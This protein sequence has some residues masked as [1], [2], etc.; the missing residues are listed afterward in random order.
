MIYKIADLYVE[1]RPQYNRMTKQSVAYQST[2]SIAPDIVI[3]I[4]QTVTDEFAKSNPHLDAEMCEYLLFGAEFYNKLIDFNGIL[5]HGSAVAVDGEVYIFT[6][7]S[8]VGKSTHTGL[9]L[10]HFG[11]RAEIINDDKPA[12]RVVNDK[13]FA[14]GTPFS[15]KYDISK[16]I[17][18]PL[19]AIC[20]IE[21][22]E[23]D[24]IS[25]V[26]KKQAYFEILNQSVRPKNELAYS[27]VLDILETIINNVPIYRLKA[28][29]S[30]N[31]VITSYEGMSAK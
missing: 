2:D 24:S 10:E 14:F 6:A 30:D 16:N 5:L 15:G 22:G 21:R 18:L 31:A 3:D 8:G 28:T 4:P 11:D 27:K 17:G 7:P 12:L 20:I 26:S 29:I 19:K 9:W 23:T 25:S 13:I 1:M